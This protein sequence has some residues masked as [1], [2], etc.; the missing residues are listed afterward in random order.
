MEFLDK[1]PFKKRNQ[2]MLIG[3]PV[4]LFIAYHFALSKTWDLYQENNRLEKLLSPIENSPADIGSLE[5]KAQLLDAKMKNYITDSS[6]SHAVLLK[7]VTY[8]CAKKG[9]LLRE[10]PK[11]VGFEEN[12]YQLITTETSTQGNFIGLLELAFKLEHTPSAGR[13][14]AVKF[15]KTMDYHLKKEVLIAKY[16]LQTV[17]EK[18]DGV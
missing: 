3:L 6:E 13:L 8:F 18:K 5:K 17:K 10:L 7:E 12:D 9:L 4:F 16:Y 2:Y 11:P 1:I 15:E 14:G